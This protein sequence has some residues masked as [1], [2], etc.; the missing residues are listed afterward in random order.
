M[1]QIKKAIL[2]S[3]L[4]LGIFILAS[5][6]QAQTILYPGLAPGVQCVYQNSRIGYH[7]C[8]CNHACEFRFSKD[9]G[10][11]HISANVHYTIGYTYT[12]EQGWPQD[13]S[14]TDEAC[15]AIL[16]EILAV[17][18]PTHLSDPGSMLGCGN[19]HSY[20]AVFIPFPTP[21]PLPPAPTPT[22]TPAPTPTTIPPVVDAGGPYVNVAC[23]AG[24]TSVKL[25]GTASSSVPGNP[26]VTLSWTTTCPQATFSSNSVINPTLSFLAADSANKPVSCKVQVFAT[27]SLQRTVTDSAD[28]AVGACTADCK[29]VIGGV[30]KS[31]VCGVCQGNGSSCNA[32]SSVDISD[33]QHAVDV[34][35]ATQRNLILLAN[36]AIHEAKRKSSKVELVKLDKKLALYSEQAQK[37]YD[38]NWKI[39]YSNPNVVLQCSATA[40]C[41]SVNNVSLESTYK[42]NSAKFTSIL[43]AQKKLLSPKTDAKAIK[44][45]TLLLAKS[46]ALENSSKD[47]L[48][49]IPDS[50]SSC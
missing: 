37:L 5:N 17:L 2:N 41:I 26:S 46:K 28:V 19:T 4:L 24:Q 33:T 15:V 49:K 36:K 7:Y 30:A 23:V 50:R 12:C 18:S 22:R 3:F 8:D 25:A 34:A 21:T 42:T 44:K 40:N 47:L 6:A 9:G 20:S 43:I 14:V 32:C 29:G 11:Y 1:R 35:A 27:D 10:Y 39:A 48:N 31:D 45:I 38:E 13:N 16:P